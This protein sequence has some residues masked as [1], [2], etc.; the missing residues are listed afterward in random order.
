VKLKEAGIDI[1]FEVLEIIKILHHRN[2]AN[3]QEIADLLFKDKSSMTY[4]VDN[5][6]KAG[7]AIRKEDEADR[8]NKLIFLTDK[9]RQLREQ[10]V[11]MA[12]FCFHFTPGSPSL[13]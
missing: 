13:W 11:P 5:M 10:L 6:V 7:L 3:Q 4:L 1:S 12:N 2:G 8:R 9:A